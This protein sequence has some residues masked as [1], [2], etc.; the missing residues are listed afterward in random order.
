LHRFAEVA[1]RE[2]NDQAPFR[3]TLSRLVNLYHRAGL[4]SQDFAASFD[5]ARQQT[6]ERTMAIRLPAKDIPGGALSRKNKMPY[7]FALLEDLLGLRAA[8]ATVA[9]AAR[10]A[11]PESHDPPVTD[12]PDASVPRPRLQAVPEREL[13]ADG[14][15][16]A[17]ARSPSASP[18]AIDAEDARMIGEVVREFSRQFA[19]YAAA[20]ALGD[21]AVT[22]WRDSGLSRQRFLEVAQVASAGMVRGPSGT[23]SAPLF[24]SRLAA[25]LNQPVG[26]ERAGAAREG[27]PC[28]STRGPGDPADTEDRIMAGRSLPVDRPGAGRKDIKWSS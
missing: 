10:R 15:R 12:A 20:T 25:A 28:A 13:A 22:R 23:A 21:W 14:I 3:A 24:R 27:R 26:D 17:T 8:S 1:A 6:K 4:S 18:P 16:S 11:A 7:F 19:D 5:A 9:I 2:F